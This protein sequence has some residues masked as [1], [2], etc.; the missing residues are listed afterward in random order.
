MTWTSSSPPD[1]SEYH[2]RTCA[3]GSGQLRPFEIGRYYTRDAYSVC[4]CL[5]SPG[6]ERVRQCASRAIERIGVAMST[7]VEGDID[8]RITVHTPEPKRT[9]AGP[10][11]E[12]L[13][14]LV[15]DGLPVHVI[16][17]I[18]HLVG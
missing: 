6:E 15:V 4:N 17:Q 3:R 7:R 8:V 9:D 5:S 11:T 14:E 2:R 16:R 12:C 18:H 13:F 1:Q 10:V